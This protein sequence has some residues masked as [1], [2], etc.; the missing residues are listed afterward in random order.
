MEGL[1]E[2]L[3]CIDARPAL[4]KQIDNQLR[5]GY[6]PQVVHSLGMVE[7]SIIRD[8]EFRVTTAD[9]SVLL[10]E[11]VPVFRIIGANVHRC[12][13]GEQEPLVSILRPVGGEC[14]VE[15]EF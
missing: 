2:S 5:D 15:P 10:D 4:L 6:R 7:H 8:S 9:E 14:M 13:G 1:N 3:R 12:I 11:G